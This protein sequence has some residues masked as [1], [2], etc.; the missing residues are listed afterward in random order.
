MRRLYSSFALDRLSILQRIS[1]GMGIILL[2][3]VALSIYSWRT[4]SAVHDQADY[5]NV[6]AVETAAVTRLAARVGQTRAQVSQYAL[7]E[8]D[9]DLREAQRFL[10]GLD[11][12]IKSVTAAY[13]SAGTDTRT[14]DQLRG[15]TERYRDSVTATIE[16]INA[17]R[18]NIAELEQAATELSTTVAAI[19]EAL[20][21][22]APDA[23]ALDDAI[24]LMEVFQSSNASAARFLAS[25]NPADSD[26]ARVNMQAMDRSLQ[27]LETRNI[28]NHRVQRFLNALKEPIDRYEKAAAGVV[29]ASERFAGVAV[30]RQAVATALIE[31]TDRIRSEAT[32]AQVGTV[33]GMMTAVTTA[34][35]LEPLASA[36]AIIAGLFLAFV[37]GKGIVRP[38]EQITDAMRA[39]AEGKTDIDIPHLQHRGAIGTMAETVRVFRDNKIEADRLAGESETERQAKVRRAQNLEVLNRR[40]EATA[41]ALTSTLASAAAG[42]QQSAEA[43]FAMTEQAGRR[44]GTVKEVAQRASA[45]IGTVANAAEELSSSIDAISESA[46]RSSAVATKTMEGAHGTNEAVRALA[47]DAQEIERVFSLIKAVAQQTNLLALNATIEAARAGQAGRGF[48]VVA[49]EVKTLAAQ[50]SQATDE[51]ESQVAKVQSVTANVVAAIQNIIGEIDEMNIIAASVA[52]AV[53]QQ[54]AATRT[55]AQ[56][57]QQ[58]LSSAVEAVNAMVGI[59]EVSTATKVEANQVLDAAGRLSRQSDDLHTEFDRFVAGVRTA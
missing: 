14:I 43:M 53:D 39:L 9:V 45:N 15:L 17:R 44:S 34:R 35:Q 37:I 47:Q 49:S 54:R 10:N 33:R 13:A 28:T 46:E 29:A 19:V 41:T 26:T 18:F 3:L 57:A 11:G 31:V 48:A 42:L 40:F 22:D 32:A 36:L 21:H 50:T 2:L 20:N 24:R 4:I 30:D 52:A 1:G 8:N 38:I 7:S 27:A 56:N 23:G 5:V 12:E 55:I 59:E 25:R 58:A 6:S 16:A 51:I